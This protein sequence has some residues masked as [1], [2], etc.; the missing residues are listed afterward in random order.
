MPLHWLPRSDLLKP[1][2]CHVIPDCGHMAPFERPG[3]VA[4]LIASFTAAHPERNG[5]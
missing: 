5:S 1:R 4:A 3:D 2:Q